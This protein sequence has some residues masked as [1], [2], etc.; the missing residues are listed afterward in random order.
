[1]PRS[2][3]TFCALASAFGVAAA[4]AAPAAAQTPVAVTPAPHTITVTG[5]ARVEPKPL[6]KTSNASIKKA[7]EQA[8]TK[9]VP[10]AIADGRAR[11][12]TLSQL[13]GIPLGALISIA[14]APASP[15]F[16]PGPFGEE[17]TFGPDEYC[18]TV[19]TRIFRRDAQGRR[20]AVGTRTRRLCRVPRYIS[21]GLTLVFSTP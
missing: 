2:H 17:G 18:G 13:A 21:A 10:L 5:V 7:I 19:R 16:F 12:A 15:Y 4:V 9:A 3:R 14:E 20:R 8:R 1:M 6:D 11:A